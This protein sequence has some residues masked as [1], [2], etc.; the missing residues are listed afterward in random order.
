MRDDPHHAEARLPPAARG[1][2]ILSPVKSLNL[3]RFDGV[4]FSGWSLRADDHSFR[5]SFDRPDKQIK[6]EL[7]RHIICAFRSTLHV[8]VFLTYNRPFKRCEPRPRRTA[9]A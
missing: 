4:F 7:Q 9:R 1:T 8:Y 3:A 2:V 5:L 6:A